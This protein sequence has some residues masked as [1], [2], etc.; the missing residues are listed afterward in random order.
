[1][2]RTSISIFVLAPTDDLNE[3]V[4]IP[5]DTIEIDEEKR[6]L[7]L[8][9]INLCETKGQLLDTLVIDQLMCSFVDTKCFIFPTYS[10]S[11][12]SM[13]PY[14]EKYIGKN[15]LNTDVELI[16]LPLCDGSH[17][18]GYIIDIKKKK[19][20]FVD[21][22]YQVKNGKRSIG[23]KLKD[24]YF[25][26]NDVKYTSYYTKRVQSDSHSCG[27]WLIAGFVGYIMG[28]SEVDENILNRQKL[29]NLMMIL[30]E[31]LDISAKKEKAENLFHKKVT[32]PEKRKAEEMED[33]DDDHDF[34]IFVDLLNAKTRMTKKYAFDDSCSEDEPMKEGHDLLFNPTS[35]PLKKMSSHHCKTA[36]SQD[37]SGSIAD[38]GNSFD[39][40]EV[41]NISNTVL[42][43]PEI[44]ALSCA[45]DYCK[46]IDNKDTKRE[47]DDSADD[48]SPTKC[49]KMKSTPILKDFLTTS[50]ILC[51]LRNRDEKIIPSIPADKKENVRYLVSN[52]SNV[53]RRSEGKKCEFFDDCGVWNTRKG[54]T[55]KSHHLYENQVTLKHVFH[56]NGLYAREKTVNKKKEYEV[57][58]PQPSNVIV[59][60]RYYT[61]LKRCPSYRRRISWI[62][63]GENAVALVEYIGLYPDEVSPHGNATHHE[64]DDYKR[65][66]P[67]LL[68]KIANLSKYQTPREIYKTLSKEDSFNGPNNFKQCQNIAHNERKK[69]N[70]TTG[71]KN[72]FADELLECMELVDGSPF[73]QQVFKSKGSLPNFILYTD[74]QI[75]DL[76]YFISH[77]RNLVLGVDRTFNL[78]SFFVTAL[79]YKN[80][81]V[82]RS[83]Q[84]DEH[85]LFIGAIY[86]HRDATFDAYHAFFSS[87]K[88]TLCRKHNIQAIEMSLDNKLVFGSDE[89]QALTKAIESVFPSS[90]RTLCTKHLKDNVV[91]YMQNKAAVP[92]NDRHKITNAIFGD[93]GLSVADDSA[94]FDQRSDSVLKVAKNYP[95]FIS[96]FNKKLNPMLKNYVIIPTNENKISPNWTN[97]NCES[98]NHI[99]K[100]D[101]DWKPGNTPRM[102]ELLHEM[103]LLHFRDF[104][105]ALYGNGNYR[106]V[107]NKKKRFGISKDNWR[108]LN[109]SERADKFKAFLK[110]EYRKSDVVKSSYANFTVTKPSTAKKPGQR[111]RVRI[112]KTSSKK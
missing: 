106:L 32:V 105:R 35:T 79:V 91:A 30:I 36:R 94:V 70:K 1:M 48:F 5:P 57:L 23:A 81:R 67:A 19:I 74:E 112:S 98:L 92:Q 96:Y 39:M 42:E 41:S 33:T 26:S 25:S 103:V 37:N 29:F 7:I 102:I 14:Y 71:K 110:N 97:N 28:I 72:N 82:V 87:I 60:N 107:G 80:Q 61:V 49:D 64:D 53:L 24:V 86:L 56:K 73:V 89:E 58:H 99:M 108:K 34:N 2:K 68:Q 51:L 65:T 6:L 43:I 62:E 11:K 78:G 88:A 50:E 69:E 8:K 93:D 16:I 15:E 75:D 44:S 95:L 3:T 12:G 10:P 52:E 63:N 101:A 45:S 55:V 84:P 83:D 85:P 47:K 31:N 17:F 27:A 54:K 100:L 77:Q 38:I 22:M 111:K 76:H 66:N 104:R 21:S 13:N 18:Y 90:T 9:K 109:E 4:D 46:N 20:V 59:L 40:H